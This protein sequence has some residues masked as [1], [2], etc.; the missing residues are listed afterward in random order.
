MRTRILYRA[1]R[2]GHELAQRYSVHDIEVSVKSNWPRLLEMISLDYRPFA[3]TEGAKTSLEVEVTLKKKDWLPPKAGSNP[4]RG[5]EEKLGT[6]LFLE[7]KAVRLRSEKEGVEFVEGSPARVRAWYLMDRRSRI[8]SLYGKAP[9]WEVCQRLMRYAL[10]KPIFHLLER[11]NMLLFH[12]A[13][14]A[15]EGRAFLLIGLNGSGK[16]SLCFRLLD[17]MDYMSD[18]FALWDGS[19]ILGFPEAIRLPVSETAPASA[20]VPEVYGKRLIL[21]D[22]EKIAIRADP[23]ASVIVTQGSQ[24][25]MVPLSWEEAA[26]R[27]HL[28]HEMTGEFPRF[29]YLGPLSQPEDQSRLESFTRSVPS[30]ALQ[31]S[32]PE[33]AKEMLLDLL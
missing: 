31:I 21:V 14:A 33:R 11:R 4:P 13:A 27:I 16:S 9:S 6:D 2:E 29:G 3:S 18:N 23:F 28:I 5:S 8:A 1:H 7:G 15:S 10:H 22:R 17:E 24:T 19:Q 30:Y 32:D 26:R 25:K 12:A 20:A